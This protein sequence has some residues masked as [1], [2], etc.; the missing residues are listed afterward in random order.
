M[1]VK[2][3]D[4]YVAQAKIKS[5][6]LEQAQHGAQTSVVQQVKKIYYALGQFIGDLD[7]VQRGIHGSS[8]GLIALADTNNKEVVNGVV[9]YLEHRIKVEEQIDS[10]RA[11]IANDKWERDDKNT[12]KISEILYALHY[13]KPALASTEAFVGNLKNRL[14]KGIRRNGTVV[15]WRYFIDDPN[16]EIQILPTAY[17]ILALKKNGYNNPEAIDSLRMKLTQ[18]QVSN[19]T[20]LAE[21]VFALYSLLKGVNDYEQ[22]E[23]EYDNI[24]KRIWK[25]EYC[26]LNNNFE[27]NVEYWMNT[28]HEYVRVP[29]QLYLLAV[30]SK[31]SLLRFY[32]VKSQRLLESI[33]TAAKESNFT[34]PYSGPYI[35]TR[36]NSILYDI[37]NDIVANLD[38]NIIYTVFYKISVYIHNIRKF[39]GNIAVRVILSLTGITMLVMAIY[40][41]VTD[42][43]TNMADLAPE[44]IGWI[45]IGLI[46]LGKKK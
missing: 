42:D 22:Y 26:T 46:V 13:I 27:Q 45:A 4:I 28:H 2:K 6:I 23:K 14:S 32:S 36:T 38:N 20:E 30:T 25:S 21:V 34:Y 44:F 16:N 35:S 7:R 3:E 17:A 41:W 33:V 39:F 18:T 29:W 15:G 40:K 24:L 12:V 10:E 31:I 19:P 11:R 43:K 1:I 5:M 9:R 8:T 37:L